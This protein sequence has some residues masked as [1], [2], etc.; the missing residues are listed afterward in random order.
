MN[1]VPRLL[2][3]VAASAALAAG[4]L[5]VTGSP[6]SAAADARS[7]AASRLEA[8][9]SGSLTLRSSGGVYDFVGVPAGV[10]LDDPAVSASTSVADAAAAHLARYGAAFGAAQSGT[11]LTEMRAG[12]TVAGDVVRYQQHVGGL[13]VMA[14][15]L[16]V[17][18][19][20]DRELSSIL[21]K[22]T[23]ATKVSAATVSSATAAATAQAAFQKSAG[24]GAAADVTALG[25]WVVDP[26]LIGGSAAAPVRTAWRFELRRG[27]AERQDGA[28]R[29]PDRRRAA[30][31]E[32]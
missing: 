7:A 21:A 31:H 22:T 32:H 2:L 28:G 24:Q 23:R 5:A 16:V 19:R 10:E 9:A 27:E 29:R 12:E 8:D 3:S 17:S 4:T 20:P 14:G 13:P 30:E 11:T 26:S 1:R 6:G 15:E 18:L 25:R